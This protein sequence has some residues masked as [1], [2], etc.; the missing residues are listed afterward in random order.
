MVEFNSPFDIPKNFTGKC[1]IHQTIRYYVNGKLHRTDGPAIEHLLADR[2]LYPYSGRKYWYSEGKQHRLDGPA[3][4]YPEGSKYWYV[5][6]RLYMEED[7]NALPEV[8][9]YKAGLEIFV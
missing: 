3:V 2:T 1:K 4:E 9:M 7:F 8:I 5:D 6:G